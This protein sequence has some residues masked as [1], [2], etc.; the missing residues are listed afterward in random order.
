MQLPDPGH[1]TVTQRLGDARTR[2]YRER[3]DE[4]RGEAGSRDEE[5]LT[6]TL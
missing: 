5:A 4:D 1:Q 2:K 3:P 6:E